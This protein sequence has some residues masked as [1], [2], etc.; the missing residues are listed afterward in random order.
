MKTKIV[1]IVGFLLSFVPYLLI[2]SIP[3]YLLG[4]LILLNSKETKK[5]KI[6]WISITLFILALTYII[7]ILYIEKMT[8]ENFFNI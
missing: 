6:Y 3:I 8:G 5:I 7:L 1:L 2:F 4:V